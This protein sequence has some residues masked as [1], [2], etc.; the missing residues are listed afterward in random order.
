MPFST[1]TAISHS[2]TV[3][4]LVLCV[5]LNVSFSNIV[6]ALL[7]IFTWVICG[8]ATNATLTDK[9]E[10]TVTSLHNALY[11]RSTCVMFYAQPKAFFFLLKK[12]KTKQWLYL[13]L[14][15]SKNL[16][17]N[18]VQQNKS[19]KKK[20]KQATRQ[21]Q[22]FFLNPSVF[23]W[24]DAVFWSCSHLHSSNYCILH[25]TLSSAVPGAAHAY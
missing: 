2:S 8:Y 5:V 23:V 24:P 10:L 17:I 14:H 13:S 16:K 18:I 11:Y 1:C 19:V 25:H 3:L 7:R 6:K 15:L 9:N 20:K 12:T 22:S 4:Y 21:I